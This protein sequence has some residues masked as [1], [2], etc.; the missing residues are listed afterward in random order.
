[1]IYLYHN[2]KKVA[3]IKKIDYKPC[4]ESYLYD[5]ACF[6]TIE[7][8][9]IYSDSFHLFNK[10]NILNTRFDI[11]I[12]NL[13]VLKD[14]LLNNGRP[15]L[16]LY[17]ALKPIS[18]EA[19]YLPQPA[20]PAQPALPT[21]VTPINLK[22]NNKNCV[23]LW[24]D[25]SIFIS[26]IATKIGSAKIINIDKIESGPMPILLRG[27]LE[28]V[29]LNTDMVVFDDYK[30]IIAIKEN[31]ASNGAIKIKITTLS[32]VKFTSNTSS[33]LFESKGSLKCL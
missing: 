11:K 33:L 16:G 9:T 6:G 30:Y 24:F 27:S 3:N 17:M 29:C 25:I 18:F 28:G 7:E 26:A 23:H 20:Q 5:N 15:C 14:A 21:I 1:M 2:G 19:Y 32:S 10:I 12:D 4:T 22:T 13:Y 8:M 31:Y